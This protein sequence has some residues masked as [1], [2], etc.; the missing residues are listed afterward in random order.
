MVSE[1]S[2]SKGLQRPQ[3]QQ[4]T[5]PGHQGQR[6]SG[7]SRPQETRYARLPEQQEYEYDD[8]PETNHY[9]QYERI[10]G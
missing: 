1:K 6:V 9:N 2:T 4:P 5:L 7:Y 8:A 10:T 3:Y